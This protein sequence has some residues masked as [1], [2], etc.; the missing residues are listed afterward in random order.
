[1]RKYSDDFLQ[2]LAEI[3]AKELFTREFFETCTDSWY[4]DE[5]TRIKHEVTFNNKLLKPNNDDAYK[6]MG[7]L[8]DYEDNYFASENAMCQY[9]GI[10][11]KLHKIIDDIEEGNKRYRAFECSPEITAKLKVIGNYFV[12]KYNKEFA[13]YNSTHKDAK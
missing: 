3:R 10:I 13:I 6:Y 8:Q 4:G 2:T 7:W 11:D 9:K 12:D 5:F 1:M